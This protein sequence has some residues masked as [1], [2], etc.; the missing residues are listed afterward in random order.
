ML[1]CSDWVGGGCGEL[2]IWVVLEEFGPREEW[3]ERTSLASPQTIA[4]VRTENAC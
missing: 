3:V 4:R 2:R 1:A